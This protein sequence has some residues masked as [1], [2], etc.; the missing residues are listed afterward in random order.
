[1]RTQSNR[2]VR[3]DNSLR[4]RGAI[5]T[6][7]WKNEPFGLFMQTVSR[8]S[9][10]R[11]RN[12]GF[13]IGAHGHALAHDVDLDYDLRGAY[14]ARHRN[15]LRQPAGAALAAAAG[16]RH[17]ALRRWPISVVAVNAFVLV[18]NKSFPPKTVAEF[19]AHVRAQPNKLAYA[20]GSAG[21]LTH[22]T[23]ALFLKR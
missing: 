20:E 5:L 3:H 2:N 1:E 18:V 22:L 13:A 14:G 11:A 10:A 21:S 9:A 15:G 19:I 6:G 8:R 17:R 12:S 16:P 7:I 23:M 4:P